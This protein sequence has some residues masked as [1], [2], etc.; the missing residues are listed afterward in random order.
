MDCISAA[1]SY[2]LSDGLT[3]TGS[4][5]CTC[6]RFTYSP[7]IRINTS[8]KHSNT[9]LRRSTSLPV[10]GSRD[11][12]GEVKT[13]ETRGQRPEPNSDLFGIQLEVKFNFV[14]LKNVNLCILA[15]KKKL[16][17]MVGSKIFLFFVF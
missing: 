3:N 2:N 12:D 15:G 10:T 16:E 14:R 6:T 4:I 1:G 13:E 11:G 8:P 17:L 5:S 7:S 9:P